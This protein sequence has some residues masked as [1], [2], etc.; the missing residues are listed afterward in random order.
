MGKKQRKKRHNNS[1]GTF[2]ENGWDMG[3]KGIEG[4]KHTDGCTGKRRYGKNE[5]KGQGRKSQLHAREDG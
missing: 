4:H 3:I 5:M 2:Q 1:T